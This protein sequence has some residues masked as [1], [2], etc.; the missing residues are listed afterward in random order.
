MNYHIRK[1]SKQKSF[2]DFVDDHLIIKVFLRNYLCTKCAVRCENI[3]YKT[4]P[5]N[6]P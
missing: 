1:V 4:F 2:V 5:P 6:T 3:H